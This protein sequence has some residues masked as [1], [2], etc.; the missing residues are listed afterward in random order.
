[1]DATLKAPPTRV[2]QFNLVKA[3]CEDWAELQKGP[4]KW[5]LSH[6]PTILQFIV[7]VYHRESNDHLQAFKVRMTMEGVNS[8]LACS[9]H[10]LASFAT[11][12]LT[13]M[14]LLIVAYG[15]AKKQSV[16]QMQITWLMSLCLH[17][18]IELKESYG[19]AR[20]WAFASKLQTMRQPT[21]RSSRTRF[22][23]KRCCYYPPPFG[24]WKALL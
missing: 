24:Q 18:N 11:P 16:L 8:I 6:H 21:R 23:S 14:L 22:S 7:D 4:V 1:M 12:C 9:G 10:L 3:F 19:M 17:A 20:S 5:L 2:V 15:F 13:K